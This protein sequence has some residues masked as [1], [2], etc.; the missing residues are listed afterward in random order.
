MFKL[1]TKSDVGSSGMTLG[2]N[3]YSVLNGTRQTKNATS[4]RNVYMSTFSETEQALNSV[5]EKVE[6]Y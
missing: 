3:V 6:L 4:C 5:S 2:K 1:I